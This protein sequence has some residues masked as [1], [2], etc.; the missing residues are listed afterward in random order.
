MPNNLKKQNNTRNNLQMH[1]GQGI[2]EH[3]LKVIF[4]IFLNRCLAEQ[5]VPAEAG[6]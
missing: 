5:R 6:R 1:E 4:P 3:N 2:P